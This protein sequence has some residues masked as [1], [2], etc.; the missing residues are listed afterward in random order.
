MKNDGKPFN[1]YISGVGGQGIGLLAEALLAATVAAGVRA[2]GV[3]THGLA[4]RGGLVESYLRIG[5]IRSPLFGRGQADLAVSLEIT[6]A[7]RAV[8]LWVCNNGAVACYDTIWQPLS[9]RRRQEASANR[10][11]LEALC[12][13]KGIGCHTVRRDLSDIR[14]QN[15]ALMGVLAARNLIPALRAEHYEKA[16]GEVLAG[17]A[18]EVNLEVFRNS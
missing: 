14:M 12:R 2:M 10:E 7:M 9:V 15:V 1:I 13:E 3:D 4:Q 16:L 6:E 18:L 17:K 8:D 5:D 11:K